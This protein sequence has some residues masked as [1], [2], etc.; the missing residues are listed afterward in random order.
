MTMFEMKTLYVLYKFISTVF[1]S[2]CTSPGVDA[3][4]WN[5]TYQ[6]TLVQ[7]QALYAIKT[8]HSLCALKCILHPAVMMVAKA[9]LP[10]PL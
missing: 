10:H 8:H 7:T 4:S 6:A 3:R 5:R 1:F 9:K 2:I